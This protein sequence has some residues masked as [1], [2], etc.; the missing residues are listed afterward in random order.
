[1]LRRRHAYLQLAE[2][3]SVD[4]ARLGYVAKMSA[5]QGENTTRVLRVRILL[6]VSAHIHSVS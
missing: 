6:G 2:N 4:T 3:M 1:M 5:V